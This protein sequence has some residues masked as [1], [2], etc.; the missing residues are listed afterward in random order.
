MQIHFALKQNGFVFRKPAEFHRPRSPGERPWFESCR[1][2]F[3]SK[4]L[5]IRD[6]DHGLC[7]FANVFV[8]QNQEV[9]FLFFFRA[10]CAPSIGNTFSSFPNREP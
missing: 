2:C 6:V 10:L 7:L 5:G 9:N 4:D 1:Q 3:E 8:F